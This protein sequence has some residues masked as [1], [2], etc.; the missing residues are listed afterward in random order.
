MSKIRALWVG[1][2]AACGVPEGI[3]E[4]EGDRNGRLFDYEVANRDSVLRRQH[5]Q[6]SRQRLA[7]GFKGWKDLADPR[8]V[9]Y[10]ERLTEFLDAS[11]QFND[12]DIGDEIELDAEAAT[13]RVLE[14]SQPEISALLTVDEAAVASKWE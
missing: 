11:I 13:L 6:T 8:R 12:R 14:A 1:L 2:P 9:E 7:R 5:G 10:A 3:S 4:I